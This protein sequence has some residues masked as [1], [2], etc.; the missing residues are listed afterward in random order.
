MLKKQ[1][2]RV[3]GGLLAAGALV[4]AHAAAIDV[5]AVVTEIAAQSVPIALIGSAVLLIFVAIKS[6]K[7]VRRA[8]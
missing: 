2:A 1:L 8:M 4:P 6:F 5:S 7:W 3:G